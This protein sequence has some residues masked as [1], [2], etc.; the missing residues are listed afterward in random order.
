MA[1]LD[2]ACGKTQPP[3]VYAADIPEDCPD[4]GEWLQ[5]LEADGTCPHCGAQIEP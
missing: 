1:W 4:C 2:Q 5:V 3:D